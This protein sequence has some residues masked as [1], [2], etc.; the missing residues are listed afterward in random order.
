[1]ALKIRPSKKEDEEKIMQL[2][3]ANAENLHLEIKKDR[4]QRA[5]GTPE[6]LVAEIDGQFAGFLYI[7][8]KGAGER[9]IAEGGDEMH[10]SAVAVAPEHRRKKVAT[11]LVRF[12]LD[13]TSKPISTH[14]DLK[15]IGAFRTFVGMG[16]KVS[17]QDD[18]RVTMFFAK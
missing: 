18:E 16:F 2:A 13:K 3:E 7:Y 10:V 11:N 12:I 17:N 5:I 1:M 6:V 14:I 4:F 15:N 8:F 9:A